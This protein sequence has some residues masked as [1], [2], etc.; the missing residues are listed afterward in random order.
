MLL[1]PLDLT[2]MLFVKDLV[3]DAFRMVCL[4]LTFPEFLRWDLGGHGGRVPW[5]REQHVWSCASA[6]GEGNS[7][8]QGG[9][10]GYIHMGRCWRVI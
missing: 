5:G 9:I 7:A 6:A 3:Q 8:A 4:T 2:S 1:V 10:V